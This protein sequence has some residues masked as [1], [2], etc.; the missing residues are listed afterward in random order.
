M[1]VV[2]DT[3]GVEWAKDYQAR[4]TER[5]TLEEAIYLVVTGKTE[6]VIFDRPALQYYVRQHPE[7]ELRVS[8]LIVGSD[9]YSF[10]VPANNDALK[11]KLDVLLLE[12]RAERRIREIADEWL[13][14]SN[15]S[16]Q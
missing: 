8:S 16:A 15:S 3:A 12:L 1:A 14:P 2:A 9:T 4:L 11:K 10:V 5:E 7:L 13:T 6:G